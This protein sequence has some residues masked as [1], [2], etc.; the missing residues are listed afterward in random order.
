[1]KQGRSIL[2]AAAVLLAGGL[3]LGLAQNAAAQTPAVNLKNTELISRGNGLFAKSC[4]VGYCHG[5]EG[6]ASRGPQLR[7]RE[8]DPRRFHAITRD[9]VPG[10]TMPSWGAVLP[11]EDIWAV[12]AYVMTLA[13][14]KLSDEAAVV[15]LGEASAP[16]PS[17]RS[18]EAQKGHDLFF[19][20]TN[21]KRCAVCHRL[22]SQG[23]PVGPDLAD[24][25]QRKSA[26]QLLRDIVEPGASLAAGF[27]QTSIAT[28]GAERVG[29]I[30]KEETKGYI[31]LY[32]MSS[33]PPPLRTIYREQIHAVN[34]EKRSSMPADYGRRYSPEELKA[35]VAY[36]KS[37]NY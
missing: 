3:F 31:K 2:W 11:D 36:L 14:T 19:D 32:D 7:D 16:Q 33:I 37:G 28:N 20:L 35:I 13:S 15:E 22:G 10:T 17:A 12:T 23:A 9:G 24:S 26:E 18:A 5:S 30:K 21:Q 27:E 1:M 6:R 8:W 29:G 4:A 34:S 25:A